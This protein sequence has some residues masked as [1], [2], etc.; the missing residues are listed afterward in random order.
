MTHKFV[1]DVTTMS[2]IVAKSAT[3]GCKP[4]AMSLSSNRKRLGWMRMAT[5][6]KRWWLVRL[7]KNNRNSSRFVAQWL[8]DWQHSSCS[9]FMCPVIS[10]SQVVWTRWRHHF[11]GSVRWQVCTSSNSW[12][13]PVLQSGTY[14]I[15][16][17]LYCGRSLSIHARYGTLFDCCSVWCAW[18]GS[19]THHLHDLLWCQLRYFTNCRRHRLMRDR[20]EKLTARFFNRRVLTSSSHLHC[21]LPDRHDND[22]INSC[23]I[24]NLST[25][26]EHAQIDS[27]NHSP[28]LFGQYIVKKS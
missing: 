21:M 8:I 4:S 9:G 27:V 7:L 24:L 19:E 28:L 11:K 5:R 20:R 15:S 26:F 25:Q 22:I 23:E 2:K 17:Y 1:D 13:E 16:T 3:Y 10:T 18:I 12:S 14:C 6:Q